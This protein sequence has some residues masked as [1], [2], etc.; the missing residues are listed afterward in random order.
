MPK[1]KTSAKAKTK[2]T[3]KPTTKGAKSGPLPVVAHDIDLTSS[4]ARKLLAERF[5]K[6]SG[7]MLKASPALERAAKVYVSA[8]KAEAEA[9]ARKEHAGNVLC[10]AIGNAKGLAGKGWDV[11]WDNRNGSIEWDK[12]AEDLKIPEATIEK[13]RRAPSRTLAF[14]LSAKA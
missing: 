2:A 6:P 10:A 1:T 11:E 5:P 12:L 8:R 13:Y 3:K 14:S 7:D 4:K 9:A